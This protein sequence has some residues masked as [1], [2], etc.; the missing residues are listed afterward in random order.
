MEV[1]N[2]RARDPETVWGN[3][4]LLTHGL[5]KPAGLPT[6]PQTDGGGARCLS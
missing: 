6:F 1:I 3:A 5:D 2:N 4:A